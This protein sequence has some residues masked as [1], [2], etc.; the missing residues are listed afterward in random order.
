MII[1]NDAKA[2]EM[3]QDL[4]KQPI[5]D[6]KEQEFL[7]SSIET[8]LFY[9]LPHIPREEIRKM[10][11]TAHIDITSTS[12]YQEGEKKGIQLGRSA[13][14]AD[15]MYLGRDLGIEI[16][17]REGKYEGRVEEAKALLMRL[18][19]KRF[20]KL[21]RSVNKQLG[22]LSLKQLEQLT[23]DFLDLNSLEDLTQWLA[24]KAKL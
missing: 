14:L 5:Y 9:K 15:G 10:I 16:G 8:I 22:L 4:L 3:A 12:W 17:K 11:N 21:N 20:G 18:L 6:Q 2:I 23:D 1:C 24:D 13:G 7:L 19:N